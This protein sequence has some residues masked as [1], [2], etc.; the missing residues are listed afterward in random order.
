[1][2]N[3]PDE[4]SIEVELEEAKERIKSFNENP[5]FYNH[6]TDDK[7]KQLENCLE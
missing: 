6:Y 5:N 2:K 7:I 3:F 4:K 1:M